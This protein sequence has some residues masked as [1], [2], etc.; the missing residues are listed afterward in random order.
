M[1]AAG[2]GV[3]VGVVLDVTV[4]DGAGD[5]V[6]V[7]VT[8]EA[9]DTVVAVVVEGCTLP[10]L[11][12]PP[13][14]ALN[15]PVNANATEKANTLLRPITTTLHFKRRDQTHCV[16]GRRTRDWSGTSRHACPPC[17]DANRIQR[18]HVSRQKKLLER[19][20]ARRLDR[21][22]KKHQTSERTRATTT[23]RPDRRFTPSAIYCCRTQKGWKQDECQLF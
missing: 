22:L 12:P 2:D 11:P 7:D 10:L 1:V 8:D 18:S 23:F 20:G 15:E 19:I 21:R 13:P 5:G 4:D 16:T 6:V 9:G 3:G 17:A 14:Q